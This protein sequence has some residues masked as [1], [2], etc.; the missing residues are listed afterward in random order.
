V[1]AL[2]LA[3]HLLERVEIAVDGRVDLAGFHHVHERVGRFA[4]EL[5]QD[6]VDR[7]VGRVR[8]MRLGGRAPLLHAGRV[9]DR[10]RAVRPFEV[11]PPTAPGLRG[12][13]TDFGDLRSEERV[14]QRRLSRAA[15]PD[16]RE[17]RIA[18]EQGE[19]ILGLHR[20]EQ[21]VFDN[22]R[23][24]RARTIVEQRLLAEEVAGTQQRDRDILPLGRLA[25]GNAKSLQKFPGIF[26]RGVRFEKD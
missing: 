19:E 1:L 7:R 12:D 3:E 22:H 9:E 18:R 8:V 25:R 14:D 6:L 5:E 2:D 13:V 11:E 17:R 4:R 23:D 15:T 26:L 10:H 24:R 16:Q 21:R 20:A